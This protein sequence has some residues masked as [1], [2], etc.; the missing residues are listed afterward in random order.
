MAKPLIDFFGA[1]EATLSEANNH[2]GLTS[3]PTRAPLTLSITL[4]YRFLRP[5]ATPLLLVGRGG[6]A[7]ARSLPR[8]TDHR[9]AIR[10]ASS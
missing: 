4:Q 10:R 8:L 1:S 7:D 9:E 3:V 2:Y 6:S 5:P